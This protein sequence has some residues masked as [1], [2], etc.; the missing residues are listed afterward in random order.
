MSCSSAFRGLLKPLDIKIAL[1]PVF[2]CLMHMLFS[3]EPSHEKTHTKDIVG[4][5]ARTNEG[6]LGHLQIG[7]W[8]PKLRPR[9]MV[10]KRNRYGFAVLF[11][12]RTIAGLTVQAEM[13][14][15]VLLRFRP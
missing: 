11:K 10:G 12:F 2:D 5:I 7:V 1:A 15:S 6:S 8:L 13:K 4:M 3:R 9:I 14:D